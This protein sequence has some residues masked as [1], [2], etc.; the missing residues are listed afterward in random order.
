MPY[1]GTGLDEATKVLLEARHLIEEGWCQGAYEDA[2]GNVCLRRALWCG[3]FA[4]ASWDDIDAAFER[5]VER[6]PPIYA[7]T[8]RPIQ[9]WNDVRG[10]TQAEVLALLDRA[11]AGGE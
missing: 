3:S 8:T 5:V 2:A 7:R 10:R 1:D 9:D 4:T 11:I 6:L